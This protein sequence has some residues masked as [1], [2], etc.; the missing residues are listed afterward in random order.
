[1][2]LI[3]PLAWEPPYAAGTALKCK[4]KRKETV[5]FKSHFADN[6]GNIYQ[7]FFRNHL[8]GKKSIQGSGDTYMAQ[9]HDLGVSG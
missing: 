1:M 5:F 7:A 2:A 6:T 9:P 3:Q 4:R 8:G